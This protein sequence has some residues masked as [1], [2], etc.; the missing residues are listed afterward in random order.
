MIQRTGFVA[1]LGLVLA[2]ASCCSEDSNGNCSD[3]CLHES[4]QQPCTNG[5][6][7]VSG[8]LRISYSSPAGW[9]SVVVEIHHSTDIE[10]SAPYAIIRP[11]SGTD[12]SEYVLDGDWSGSATYWRAGHQN[13]KVDGGNISYD[14][15]YGC[16]CYTLNPGSATLNLAW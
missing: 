2:L 14:K 6:P 10:G 9:D 13:V 5:P 16:T 7:P 1:S 15:S 4:E 8:T 12:S 11:K 3:G